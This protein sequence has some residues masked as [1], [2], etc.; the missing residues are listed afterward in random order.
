MT[1]ERYRPRILIGAVAQAMA[2]LWVAAC[3]ADR[4]LP[5]HASA[6]PDSATTPDS[7]TAL[8]V[9][10]AARSASPLACEL[11]VALLSGR[12]GGFERHPDSPANF[13]PQ[14]HWIMQRSTDAARIAPLRQALADPDPC[15]RRIAPRLLARSNHPQAVEALLEALRDPSPAARRSAA[16]GLG[17]ASDLRAIDALRSALGDQ[18]PDVR[19]A[20]AWALARLRGTSPQSPTPVHPGP[21][22]ALA[23]SND[24][25]TGLQLTARRASHRLR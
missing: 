16:V 6:P 14:V 23:R 8:H 9:L 24:E 19:R 20:A 10:A 12:Q 13:L 25:P 15:V 5:S 11:I 3:L 2:V 4:P 22:A 21:G 7:A 1:T 17:Y 18:H